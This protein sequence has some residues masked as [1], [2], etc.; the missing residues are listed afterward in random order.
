MG[1]GSPTSTADKR[2][3]IDIVLTRQTLPRLGRPLRLCPTG[4]QIGDGLT[5]NSAEA[6]DLPRAVLHGGSYTLSE[7]GTVMEAKDQARERRLACGAARRPPAA[8]GETTGRDLWLPSESGLLMC[9]VP[10][11]PPDPA[12]PPRSPLIFTHPYTFPCILIDISDF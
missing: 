2:S 6:A 5:K 1:R 9:G 11:L 12:R 10:H 3:A 7:E 8:D 4:R